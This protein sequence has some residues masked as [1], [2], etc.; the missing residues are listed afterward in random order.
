MEKIA[1]TAADLTRG[2][3]NVTL[4]RR[5][6]NARGLYILLI[7]PFVYV[8]IFNYVPIYGII[9]AFKRFQPRQGVWN[10]PWVG[11]Y[12]FERF[13]NSPNFFNI[14]RN[15]VVLSIYNLIAGFPLP[16]V[17]AICLNHCFIYRFKKAVQTL[18]FAPYFLSAVVLVGLIT[19][20]LAMRTGGVNLIFKSLGLGEVNFLGS[21]SMFPHVYVWA[22]VWKNAGYSA[23]IYISSLAA[24][25]PTYHEAAVID[26]ANLWQRVWHIDLAVIRPIIIIMLILSMGNILGGDFET[27]YLLQNP[28]NINTSEIISTYVYKVGLGANTSAA[29]GVRAD[30]SFGT[31]IGLFQNVVGVIL[32][33]MVNRIA[34]AVSGEGMF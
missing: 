23:V 20:L 17:L 34:N 25:D 27:T 12:N 10:S 11:F 19:Q 14:M 26:G 7:I 22:Y 3:S 31:A 21:A 30:Y 8:V 13:F 16:I 24:V 4:G 15:T 29:I 5:I 6:M 33:L 2:K 18:T 32:T 28:L 9:M 1:G